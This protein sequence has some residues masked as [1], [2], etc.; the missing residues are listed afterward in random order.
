M[1]FCVVFKF[2]L[3]VKTNNKVT[4]VHVKFILPKGF[5]VLHTNLHIF[6]GK[7]DKDALYKVMQMYMYIC[8]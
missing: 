2:D 7:V 1:K 5:P 4:E 6:S 3:K 8:L